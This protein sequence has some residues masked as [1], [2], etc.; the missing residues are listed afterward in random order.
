MLNALDLFSGIGGISLAL[1]DWINTVAYCEGDRHAQAVLLSRMREGL[2]P[3]R[4]IW[5]DVRTLRGEWLPP[6]DI[7]VGGFP[8]QDIS[9]AGK[10]AGLDG[11]RSALF[12]EI[13]R[14]AE[15][16]KPTFL[17]LENVPAI[18]TRGLDR[19][20]QELTSLGYDLRWTML[21]AEDV[22]ANHRRERW[23]CLAAHTERLKLRLEQGRSSGTHGQGAAQPGLDGTPESLADANSLRKPQC[24]ESGHGSRHGPL[25]R[26][27]ALANSV[28]ERSS[29]GRTGGLSAEHA[30]ACGDG[31]DGHTDGQHESSFGEISR[32]SGSESCGAS[33]WAVEPDVG[34]VAHGVPLR[35]DR[36]KR[37]GNAVVPLQAREAFKELM[38]IR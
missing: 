20:I 22:G 2:L 30:V 18:R 33:W 12:F 36:L 38:G 29:N 1:G 10:G 25:D 16:I 7:I 32:G 34:R 37:L 8:C 31:E 23:F 13:C 26:S 11:E 19:V 3:S 5:D 28:R 15:E 14:L 17:F 9:V 21:S 35:L 6:V 27:E 24:A 4:P